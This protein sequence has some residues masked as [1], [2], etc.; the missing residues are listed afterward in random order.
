MNRFLANACLAS[1]S[2]P[3]TEG[4]PDAID[5]YRDEVHDGEMYF[6]REPTS[7]SAIVAFRGSEE[8]TDFVLDMRIVPICV[9]AST[10]S[11]LVRSNQNYKCNLRGMCSCSKV[12]SGFFQMFSGLR[13]KVREWTNIAKKE[14]KEIIFTGHSLGGAMAL[15]ANLDANM[16]EI[17]TRAVVFGAPMV[18]NAKFAEMYATFCTVPTIVFE[19]E[20]DPIPNL[21]WLTFPLS[22]WLLPFTL[23]YVSTTSEKKVLRDLQGN[24]TNIDDTKK[25]FMSHLSK[26]FPHIIQEY[27][28]R[29]S[30]VD[31]N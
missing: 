22:S 7:G 1:Y 19:N 5:F 4:A 10:T 2:N 28:R 21:K 30:T 16:L 17:K 20:G 27:V 15:L 29:I 11:G 31:G 25:T 3:G 26:V 14:G 24:G 9:A 8:M 18:G 13:R 12:H 23:Q 6:L